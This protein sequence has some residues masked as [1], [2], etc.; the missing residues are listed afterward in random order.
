M[1]F[2]NT[3]TLDIQF[4]VVDDTENNV[5]E[6]QVDHNIQSHILASVGS[7]VHSFTFNEGEHTNKIVIP[8]YRHGPTTTTSH[9][10]FST[11]D[12]TAR[13]VPKAVVDACR[14]LPYMERGG[15]L[16]G[17]YQS[18]SGILT[19]LPRRSRVDIEI[20]LVDDACFEN[21]F[22]LFTVQLSVP[23]GIRIRGSVYKISVTIIDDDAA[24][25][26]Q[27]SST[28]PSGQQ[29]DTL[30]VSKALDPGFNVKPV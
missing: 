1:W 26:A 22:K 13:G 21:S 4:A 5:A 3:T 17:D 8:V 15:A 18:S 28:C 6:P 19:F 12:V 7:A 27:R 10:H 23:G 24:Y 20:P 9:I 14:K 25:A 2:L 30:R 11:Y 16:C 29:E